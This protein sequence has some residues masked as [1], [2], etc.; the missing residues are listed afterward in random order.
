MALTD[1]KTALVTG[2]SGGIGEA[3]VRALTARGINVFAA[4][5][6][7]EKLDALASETGCQPIILDVQD[8]DAIYAQLENRE[9][10]ILIN[11][12]GLGRGFESLFTADPNDIE[13]TL[14]TNVI[15]AAHVI[16]AT[17]AGM[18]ARN[19][20]H[21]VNI[22]SVAGLYPIQSSV[23]GSSKGAIHLMSQNLRIE[24]KGTRIRVTEI[25][26]GRVETNFF[27]VA[28][29]DPEKSA[30]AFAG[31]EALQA[32]DISDAIVYALDTPWRVNIGTIE[33]SPTE[34][35]FGGMQITPAPE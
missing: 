6:R 33:L 8:K 7:R 17:V 10:D 27:N 19:R 2:A 3:C 28:V 21:V 1:Y 20:G 31:F 26:P 12:A 24:L 32:G 29:N 30:K 35:S 18:V 14:Q 9:I 15:G 34:Q 4:A 25:C 22:G 23:Y 5:R 13:T 11:N 16:R